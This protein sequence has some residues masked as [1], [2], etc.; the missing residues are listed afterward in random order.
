V[1]KFLVGPLAFLLFAPALHPRTNGVF[2][3]KNQVKKGE[4]QNLHQRD[5]HHA[6]RFFYSVRNFSVSKAA[7]HKN[8]QKIVPYLSR[9]SK[10]LP[11]I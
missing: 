7:E 10:T 9:K 2:F 4:A 8:N 1:F 11:T 5:W 6:S 3:L